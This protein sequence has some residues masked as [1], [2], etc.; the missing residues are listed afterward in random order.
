MNIL[1]DKKVIMLIAILLVFTIG[2][3]IIVNK[4]SYAF[5]YDYDL[6]SIYNSTI[7]TIKKCATAYAENNL[8]LFEN[9]KIIYIKVQDLIDNNLLATNEDGF[10]TNPLQEN[11]IINSNVIKIK[12]EDKKITIEIDS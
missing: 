7:E 10:I 2:Y 12:Y 1:K 5:S 11:T 4:I 3:F 6:N 9:E 8:D